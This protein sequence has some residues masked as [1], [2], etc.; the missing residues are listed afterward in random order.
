VQE[1]RSAFLLQRG[2]YG[3]TQVTPRDAL[4]WATT[5]SAGCLGRPELGAIAPGAAAD[6]ALFTLAIWRPVSRRR[7]LFCQ[8]GFVK[9][10]EATL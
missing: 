4:R 9:G 10:D 3:V 1:V 8:R 6:L 5:G 7:M 2:R